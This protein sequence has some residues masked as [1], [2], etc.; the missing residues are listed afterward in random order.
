MNGTTDATTIDGCA[1][2]RCGV[3]GV[4]Q[5]ARRRLWAHFMFL[6]TPCLYF[7]AGTLLVCASC[8]DTR[9]RSMLI[10]LL[11]IMTVYGIWE[12]YLY[13]VNKIDTS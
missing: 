12:K 2:N 3:D 4:W 5:L 1:L 13:R 11:A 6:L 9:G 7:V 10:P 8:M